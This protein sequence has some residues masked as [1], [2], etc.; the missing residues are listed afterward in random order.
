M[1][2]ALDPSHGRHMGKFRKSMW[3]IHPITKIEI[4]KNGKWAEY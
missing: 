3:E 1:A 2:D 4:Y